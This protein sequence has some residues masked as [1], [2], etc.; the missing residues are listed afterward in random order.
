MIEKLDPIGNADPIYQL[1]QNE[2]RSK[3]N[4]LIEAVN[5]LTEPPKLQR[6]RYILRNGLK[7]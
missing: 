4:E 2:I 6:K 5:N 7:T 1:Q 3:I